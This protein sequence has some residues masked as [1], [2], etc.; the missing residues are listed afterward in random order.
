MVNGDI[1]CNRFVSNESSY[2]L[3]MAT[4]IFRYPK[5]KLVQLFDFNGEKNIIALKY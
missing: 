1:N 5:L 2:K 4:V 3:Y